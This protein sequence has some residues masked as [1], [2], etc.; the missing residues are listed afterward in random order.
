VTVG[1]A[2]PIE[3]PLLDANVRGQDSVQAAVYKNQI[4]WFWGDTLYESGGLGN[5]RTAGAR[6]QLPSQ[7]GLDPSQGVN[8]DYFVNANGWAREMMPVS[9]PGAMWIDGVFTVRDNGG[10]ERLFGRNARYLDLATNVE[11]GL[12]LFNDTTNTFQRFQT[13]ALDAPITPQ[14]H[15]FKHMV[16]GQEYIYFSLTYPN[17]RV[18]ADWQHV[19][20][21][22]TWE[23]FTPLRANSRYDSAN[24]P[25]DLDGMGNPIFGWKTNT[26]PLSYEMLEDLVQQGHLQREQLPFRLEDFATGDEVRL[27]RSSVHWNEFRQSWIMIGVESWGDSFLGE[28]WFAEAP[29]PEGPWVDAVKV[30]THNRGSNSDYTFYN[31]TSH[32]FFDQDGGRFIYFEGTYANTFSG[33]PNQTPL[34]DYN[35]M[36]YRLDLAAI[37]DLFPRLPGDYNRDAVVDAADYVVWRRAMDGELNL[38]ADGSGNG[39]IDAADYQ[40]WSANFGAT[41]ATGAANQQVVAEPGSLAVICLGTFVTCLM[42]RSCVGRR[43]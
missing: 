16:D 39:I 31:P 19:I 22:S 24:P 14:G 18:K 33:N 41:A 4:Y 28:V 29:A 1:A 8:L 12:A 7:G 36:M 2:V 40:V 20:N 34:Y 6:S 25:L 11:H 37:P 9:Q 23:A 30:A 26:D 27:H 38:A 13:Y 17:V 5:F 21:I 15:S 3:E 35:Q 32:P 43:G 10:Q 42:R